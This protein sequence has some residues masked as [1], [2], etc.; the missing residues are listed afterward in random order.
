MSCSG[1]ISKRGEVDII[2]DFLNKI[3]DFEKSDEKTFKIMIK[4]FEWAKS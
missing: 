1:N 3:K 4:F 2:S